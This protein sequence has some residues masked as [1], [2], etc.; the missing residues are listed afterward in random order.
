MTSRTWK[1][2]I[3]QTVLNLLF[4]CGHRRMFPLIADGRLTL[5]TALLLAPHLTP[6]NRDTLLR[7]STHRSKREIEELIAEFAPREDVRSLIRKLPE[8][9][10]RPAESTLSGMGSSVTRSQGNVQPSPHGAATTPLPPVVQPLAPGRYKVQ[11]T[12]SAALREKL[13]RLQ[14][15]MHSQIP[16]GDLGAVIE[17]A[18][19]DTLERLEARRFATTKRPRKSLSNTRMSP[20]SRYIPA[21]VRRAVRERDGDRCRYV[22]ASGR[23]CQERHRLHY[24]HLHTFAVGGDHRPENIRLMC[25]AHN[26]YL[27]ECDYGR[28]AMNRFR[29]PGGRVSETATAGGSG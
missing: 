3:S 6:E 7:R 23:R 2:I 24:H 1:T 14:A 21:A 16:D 11:F 25:K 4:H 18:V 12:A 29:R 17:A 27:A 9:T 15:L 26:H 13:E 20:D 8:P 19:T 5:S 28:D 22:D 10:S